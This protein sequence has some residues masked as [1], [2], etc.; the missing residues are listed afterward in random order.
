MTAINE[1]LKMINDLGL[2]TIKVEIK[3]LAGDNRYII[4]MNNKLQTVGTKKDLITFLDGVYS[5]C[6]ELK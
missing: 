4:R 2:L 1:Y 5:T 3:N 6:Q